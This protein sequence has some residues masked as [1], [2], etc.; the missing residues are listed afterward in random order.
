ML[1]S[2]NIKQSAV[3]KTGKKLYQQVA[4]RNLFLA[5]IAFASKKQITENGD[6]HPP[7]Y[8]ISAFGAERPGFYYIDGIR[9]KLSEKVEVMGES[10]MSDAL[11]GYGYANQ[12]FSIK[13]R[14][15]N[16]LF[17]FFANVQKN[18]KPV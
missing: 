12:P 11:R 4:G 18:K 5:E 2:V 9:I 7:S 1:N 8:H 13:G 6:I 15:N 16:G 10:C 17:F 3:N 14:H